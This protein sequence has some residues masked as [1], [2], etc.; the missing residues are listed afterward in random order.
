MKPFSKQH[1]EETRTYQPIVGDETT[2]YCK[3]RN[4]EEDFTCFVHGVAQ[5]YKKLWGI[6]VVNGPLKEG[7]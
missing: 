2:A 6:G 7:S 3:C 1:L 4:D 5:A